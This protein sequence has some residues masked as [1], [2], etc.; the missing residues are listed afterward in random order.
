[1]P[2][3]EVYGAEAS[4]PGPVTYATIYSGGISS[5]RIPEEPAGREPV[6][7]EPASAVEAATSA[8]APA[9]AATLTAA[10]I[11]SLQRTV[12][13]AAVA[14][15][16]AA[17]SDEGEAGAD[18]P[19]GDSDV[20]DG[21]RARV[22]STA[23]TAGPL[24]APRATEPLLQRGPDGG[25]AAP[26]APAVWTAPFDLGAVSDRPGASVALTDIASKLQ[27]FKDA[28]FDELDV[29]I[30]KCRSQAVELSGGDPLSADEVQKLSGI[31][32]AAFASHQQALRQMQDMIAAELS[33]WGDV[34][35]SGAAEAIAEKLHQEFMG[36]ASASTLTDAKEALG[37]AKEFSGKIADY[38]GWAAKT[39]VVIKSAAKFEELK[40]SV[41]GFKSKLGEAKEV[42]ELAESLGVLVGKVGAMPGG[43][44][45]DIAKIKAGF[46]IVDFVLSKSE[47]PVI[48]Q[49]WS[50]YIKPT[51]EIALKQLQKLDDMVDHMTRDS[52]EKM[53]EWWDRARRGGGPP[54]ITDTGL[55]GLNLSK[56]FPG[57]QAMLNF[58]WSVF[59]GGATEIPAGIEDYF[60]KFKSQF[61]A[62][63]EKDEIETDD[64]WYNLWN[65]FG[66]T[67][68]TN[69]L[70]WVTRHKEEVWGMLYG[71]LPHP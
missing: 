39:K 31:G 30:K 29:V 14:R 5:T 36:G 12:G 70:P 62:G 20:G 56:Y 37:K 13:N 22:R 47:V 59:R 7:P 2:E 60:V 55:V 16:V 19:D 8:P 17:G 10:S 53:D 69:L 23:R 1:M 63:N 65:A 15:L 35:V 71:R 4:D 54:S 44:Q 21:P 48:G 66:R 61:N 18:P 40:K 52:D 33:K 49:L 32:L 46:T 34:D 6:A 64:H 57:G 42:V 50:G 51:A 58:M 9:Q 28:G 3:G 38:A 27:E 11:L 26:A 25:T 67:K 43:T 41:E 45:G 68:A 24:P